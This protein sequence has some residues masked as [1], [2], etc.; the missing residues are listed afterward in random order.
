MARLV[1]NRQD[2]DQLVALAR[3]YQNRAIE[4]LVRNTQETVRIIEHKNRLVQRIY[5]IYQ[6]PARHPDSWLPFIDFRTHFY[7]PA[8]PIFGFYVD[9]LI[10]NVALIWAMTLL[11]YAM[12]Y[13]KFLGETFRTISILFGNRK[14]RIKA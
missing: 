7:A 12:L 11:L 10:F 14:R 1:H 6:M 5:P 13:F 9:T 3:A 8:K 4:E 2:R